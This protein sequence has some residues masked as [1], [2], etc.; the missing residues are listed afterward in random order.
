MNKKR[1]KKRKNVQWKTN[2]KSKDQLE[3]MVRA[4]RVEN[5]Q[6]TIQVKF[7]LGSF[8]SNANY[9]N[10]KNFK[11]HHSEN[12]R[13]RTRRRKKLFST[14]TISTFN[15]SNKVSTKNKRKKNYEQKKQKSLGSLY[16]KPSSMHN[17]FKNCI[18]G[19]RTCEVVKDYL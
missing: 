18:T 8:V 4:E 3:N 13:K 6:T 12:E 19:H 1:E 9:R 11:K 10:K 16:F 7:I 15:S 14:A 2:T 17:I 5:N